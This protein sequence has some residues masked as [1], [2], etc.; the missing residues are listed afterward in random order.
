MHSVEIH[1]VKILAFDNDQKGASAFK[2]RKQSW[3]QEKLSQVI[4]SH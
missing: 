4:A 1:P 2:I 3:D